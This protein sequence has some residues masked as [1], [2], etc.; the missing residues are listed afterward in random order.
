MVGPKEEK[1][2]PGRPV[3]GKRGFAEQGGAVERS[4]SKPLLRKRI[5]NRRGDVGAAFR[6]DRGLHHEE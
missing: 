3:V 1:S 5:P 2:E 4:P 6:S